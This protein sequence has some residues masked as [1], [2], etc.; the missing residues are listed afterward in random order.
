MAIG[1][2]STQSEPDHE[3]KLVSPV[4]RASFPEFGRDRLRASMSPIDGEIYKGKGLPDMG[5]NAVLVRGLRF[6]P[7]RTLSLEFCQR[8]AIETAVCW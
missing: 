8:L 2:P 7:K 1:R 4:W 6:Q 5:R 3:E